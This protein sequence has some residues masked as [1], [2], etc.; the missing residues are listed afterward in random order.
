MWCCWISR[1]D[2]PSFNPTI[3]ALWITT[4]TTAGWSRRSRL[5]DVGADLFEGASFGLRDE[6]SNENKA[7]QADDAVGE[8]DA[9]Y[10]FK[11]VEKG[12]GVGEQEG[13]DPQ[14]TDGRGN[15]LGADASRKYLSDQDPEIGKAHV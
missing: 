14:G 2:D 9:G 6:G 11:L 3:A 12:K 8:E 4:R 5:G 15:A 10:A 13:S 7:G 1:N